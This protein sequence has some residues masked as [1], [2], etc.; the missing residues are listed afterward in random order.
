MIDENAVLKEFESVSGLT[1]SE[2]AK[3]RSVCH[4]CCIN[5]FDRLK[6]AEYER[7]ERIINLAAAECFYIVTLRTAVE[8]DG[9]TSIKAGDVT[10]TKDNLSSEVKAKALK[11]EAEAFAACLL[12]DN[13]FWFAGV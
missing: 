9:V 10:V 2:C 3:S 1:P 4:L 12:T 5:I 8:D 13:D 6:K 7:D 11:D